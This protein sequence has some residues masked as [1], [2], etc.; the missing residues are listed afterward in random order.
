TSESASMAEDA[1]PILV[2]GLAND[3]DVDGDDLTITRGVTELGMASVVDNKIEY[4]PTPNS[5]GVA[6]VSYTLSDG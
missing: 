3:S 6:I 2:D 4:T 1:S 5:N